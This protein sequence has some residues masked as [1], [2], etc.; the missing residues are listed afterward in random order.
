MFQLSTRL[1]RTAV[2]SRHKL[3]GRAALALS[4]L[5]P[6]SFRLPF[7]PLPLSPPP[8]L[9]L[10][11]PFRQTPRPSFS[12]FPPR[13]PY[14]PFPSRER[15]ERQRE[16]ESH[17]SS[18]SLLL[19]ENRCRILRHQIPVFTA[20]PPKRRRLRSRLEGRLT[21]ARIERRKDRCSANNDALW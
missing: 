18:G 1:R 15:S 4:S 12:Y 21:F 3:R 8:S 5:S 7:F 9:P 6:L 11:D 19:V 17:S 10:F 14:L 2:S 16:R 20:S 13:E